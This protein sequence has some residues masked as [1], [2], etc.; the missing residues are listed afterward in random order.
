MNDKIDETRIR[1]LTT[2]ERKSAW[3]T[4][5][6]VV[7]GKPPRRDQ[8]SYQSKNKMPPWMQSGIYIGIAIVILAAFIISAYKINKVGYDS[9]IVSFVCYNM[10]DCDPA[11]AGAGVKLA[12]ASVGVALVLMAEVAQITFSA[13]LSTIEEDNKAGK[14]VLWILVILS[15]IIALGGNLELSQPWN[16]GWWDWVFAVMP[17]VI[18]IGAGWLLKE[19]MMNT[20]KA[21][22]EEEL[23]FREKYEGW[24]AI[25]S[26]PEAEAN[27]RQVYHQALKDALIE[28]NKG[29]GKARLSSLPSQV[30]AKLVYSEV[31]ATHEMEAMIE[32]YEQYD[33]SRPNEKF[34]PTE[35]TIIQKMDV[36]DPLLEPSKR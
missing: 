4:A 27:W 31:R 33:A 2:E 18:V 8:F 5:A 28:A 16:K 25:R 19:Q 36:P 26:N 29:L 13:G 35:L 21:R 32:Q 3:E 6:S 20:I 10:E 14:T 11:D 30:W 34:E 24:E 1:G 7:I 22:R 23:A 9:F 17:P 15:S 12:A